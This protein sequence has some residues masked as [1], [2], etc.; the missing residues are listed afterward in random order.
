[1]VKQDVTI[2]NKIIYKYARITNPEDNQPEQIKKIF[3]DIS[4]VKK[5]RYCG[6]QNSPW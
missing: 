4:P 1:M 5:R 6:Y 3:P 2:L